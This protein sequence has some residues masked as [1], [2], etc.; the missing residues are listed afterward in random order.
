MMSIDIESKQL[1]N[2]LQKACIECVFTGYS[3]WVQH[4][5]CAIKCTVNIKTRKFG[6][7]MIYLSSWN[8]SL[9]A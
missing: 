1:Y 4:H 8:I 3:E 6:T 5:F 7:L 2:V 9:Y